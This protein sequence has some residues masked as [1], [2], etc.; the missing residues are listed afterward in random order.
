[1]GDDVNIYIGGINNLGSAVLH[2]CSRVSELS[3]RAKLPR[4]V[5][6]AELFPFQW[7]ALVLSL[8]FK[9]YKLPCA[10]NLYVNDT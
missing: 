3:F 5:A 4:R 1:M 10:V 2:A 6:T 7:R 8:D 9:A